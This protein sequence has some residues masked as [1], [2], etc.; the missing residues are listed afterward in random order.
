MAWDSRFCRYLR[1]YLLTGV[2][3]TNYNLSFMTWYYVLHLLLLLTATCYILLVILLPVMHY[4]LLLSADYN[5][6]MPSPHLDTLCQWTKSAWTQFVNFHNGRNP[7]CQLATTT[8][9][10]LPSFDK[11]CWGAPEPILS[12]DKIPLGPS[13]QPIH[14]HQGLG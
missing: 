6:C 2:T 1:Y 10:F 3:T 13:D 7:F 5:L 14:M 11:M 9:V 12:I 4:G 8:R